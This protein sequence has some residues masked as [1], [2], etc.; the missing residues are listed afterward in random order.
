MDSEFRD[1]LCKRQSW[2]LVLD[3]I[4]RRCCS[5][6]GSVHHP[7]FY[8]GSQLSTVDSYETLLSLNVVLRLFPYNH[9]R[10][11]YTSLFILIL[12]LHID[13]HRRF[14]SRRIICVLKSTKINGMLSN[15]NRF[16]NPKI[17]SQVVVEIIT[18]WGLSF[19]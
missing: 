15:F 3:S 9:Y 6:P 2:S 18:S 5:Q 10:P 19:P 11:K 16:L 17:M 8:T 13:S 12:F 1:G 4:R 14:Y 7:I